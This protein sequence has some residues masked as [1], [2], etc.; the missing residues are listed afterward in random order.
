MSCQERKVGRKPTVGCAEKEVQW[1]IKAPGPCHTRL[2]ES[3][4]QPERKILAE[5]LPLY[6]GP[7]LG[8]SLLEGPVCIQPTER[9]REESRPRETVQKGERDEKRIQDSCGAPK[10]FYFCI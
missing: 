7:G 5:G 4:C 6:R 8:R 1:D 9:D 2:L 3:Y 10:I